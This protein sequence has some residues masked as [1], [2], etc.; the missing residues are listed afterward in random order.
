MHTH[1][2]AQK[3]GPC[4]SWGG[5]GG[6]NPGFNQWCLI[7]A[8]GDDTWKMVVSP[9]IMVRFFKF[10]SWLTQHFDHDLLDRD[11]VTHISDVIYDVFQTTISHSDFPIESL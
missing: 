6:F 7:N 8:P 10:K 5:G 11:D 9:L 3:L 1:R 4:P 2:W